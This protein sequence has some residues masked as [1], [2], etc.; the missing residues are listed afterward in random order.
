VV[1]FKDLKQTSV[2][3]IEENKKEKT[4]KRNIF[5]LIMNSLH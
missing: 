3:K 5:K 4:E 1:R 2:I